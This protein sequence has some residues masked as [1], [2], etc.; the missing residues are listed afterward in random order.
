MKDQISFFN[1]LKCLFIITFFTACHGNSNT[2]ESEQKIS[3][4]LLVMENFDDTE[5][6]IPRTAPPPPPEGVKPM[7]VKKSDITIEVKNITQWSDGLE[8]KMDQ[9]GAYIVK[10]TVNNT[11]YEKRHEISIRVPVE[12]F[13]SVLNALEHVKGG[14]V[15]HKTLD[16]EDVTAAYFDM[17][18]RLKTRKAVLERYQALLAKAN[19]VKDIIQIEEAA[20]EVQEEIEA[21]EGRLKY[22]YNQSAYS[23][24]FLNIIE[25]IHHETIRISFGQRLI[26]GFASGWQGFLNALVL[27]MEL[28]VVIIIGVFAFLMIRRQFFKKQ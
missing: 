17:A 14:K 20:R 6:A 19:T 9:Y 8:P 10:E 26:D 7:L 1:L 22:L 21:A 15:I 5:I 23:T 16:V 12:K 11:E 2:N 24:I 27:I 4:D 13:D 18:A 25:K 3:E 28:W